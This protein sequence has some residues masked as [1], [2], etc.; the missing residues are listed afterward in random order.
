MSASTDVLLINLWQKCKTEG[1]VRFVLIGNV[2]AE[3]GHVIFAHHVLT[4][5]DEI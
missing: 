5:M 2:A 3:M 1:D 4:V